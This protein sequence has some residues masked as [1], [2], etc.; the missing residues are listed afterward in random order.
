MSDSFLDI[1]LRNRGGGGGSRSGR[2][3]FNPGPATEERLPIGVP[4]GYTAPRPT[5]LRGM[6][7]RGSEGWSE[8]GRGHGT[9]FPQAPRYYD[10]D[11][12][13]VRPMSPAA[14]AAIQDQMARAGL[15]TSDFMMGVWDPATAEAYKVLL[16]MA[17]AQGTTVEQAMTLLG[18][19]ERMEWDPAT[20]TY[21]SV[22][23]LGA[24]AAPVPELVTRVTDPEVLKSVFRRAAIETIGI[25][26]SEEQL[27]RAADAYNNVERQRQQEAYDTQ[28][29]AGQLG[30]MT[31]GGA[32]V[33]GEVVEIPSAEGWIDSYIRKE[34]PAGV[35]ENQAL[36]MVDVFMQTAGS[37]AWGVGRQI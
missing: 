23:G 1:P 5:N 13:R 15:L 34:D 14:I 26:W 18:S 37:T 21:Q 33:A 25:G 6:T 2:P 30:S 20:G 8:G 16:G 7:T 28:L 17:N 19:G 27:Q 11:E 29:A 9:I 36:D 22:G 31:D 10:G 24:G 4:E 35:A 12:Y 3:T 32:P